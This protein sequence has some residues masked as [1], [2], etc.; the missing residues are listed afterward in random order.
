MASVLIEKPARGNFLPL[1]DGGYSLQFSPLMLYREG[2]GIV[3]FCQADVT[4]RT[5]D[6]P[7]ATRLV[8]NMLDY[9]SAYVPPSVGKVVYVG[10][11]AGRRHLEQIGLT[12]VA[13][14]G[15][16][17]SAGQVLIVGP[18][19]SESLAANADGLRQWIKAGGKVLAVGLGQDEAN[20][21]LPFAIKTRKQEYICTVF[22]P[23]AGNSLLASVGPADVMN[24]DPREVELISAGATPVGDGVL[25]VATDANVVF[26][27][28]APGSSTTRNTTTRSGPSGG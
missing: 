20:R 12:V 9:V 23:P 10:E 2:R 25:A 8:A 1:L 6:D 18:G 17:P 16:V 14:A 7:A 24:R 11:D 5:A 21:F 3:L 28:L 22:S 15:G 4:G 19:G 13:P 27:Q 26:C